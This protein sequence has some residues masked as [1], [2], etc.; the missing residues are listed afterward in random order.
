MV[1]ARNF[2]M[3][4]FSEVHMQGG[5][6]FQVH[7]E[8]DK[9]YSRGDVYS[10]IVSEALQC[11][12]MIALTLETVSGGELMSRRQSYWVVWFCGGH[13]KPPPTVAINLARHCSE[14]RS[15]P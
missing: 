4:E 6:W 11:P 5:A 12:H 14:Q 7:R 1:N 3:T 8:E 15:S 10:A 9:R 13:R 2:A